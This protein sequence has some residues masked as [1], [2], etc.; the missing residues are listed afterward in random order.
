MTIIVI[1]TVVAIV[2]GVVTLVTA[3]QL[4]LLVVIF[5]D[6]GCRDSKGISSIVVLH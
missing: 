6:R 5:D 1:I 3:A 2:V 4:P